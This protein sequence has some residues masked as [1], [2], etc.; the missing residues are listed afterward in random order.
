M[1]DV[2]FDHIIIRFPGCDVCITSETERDEGTNRIRD[3]LVSGKDLYD[4]SEFEVLAHEWIDSGQSQI[5]APG[6][7]S[8]HPVE[9]HPESRRIEQTDTIEIENDPRG[10]CVGNCTDERFAESGGVRHVEIT[11]DRDDRHSIGRSINHEIENHKNIRSERGATRH[12]PRR[13]ATGRDS[14]ASV[15]C[16]PDH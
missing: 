4:P 13:K 2:Y 6:S 10:L 7:G 12:R 15:H 8:L 1:I 16:S 14:R 9:D 5:A 3:R 11:H